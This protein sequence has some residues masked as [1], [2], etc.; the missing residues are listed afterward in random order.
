[1]LTLQTVYCILHEK[2]LPRSW[3]NAANK[4]R[5]CLKRHTETNISI[6]CDNKLQILVWIEFVWLYAATTTTTCKNSQGILMWFEL[7]GFVPLQQPETVFRFHETICRTATVHAHWTQKIVF[8][9][10]YAAAWC[11]V[12]TMKRVPT[13]QSTHICH[14]NMYAICMWKWENNQKKNIKI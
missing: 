13:H 5:Q 6:F 1:M 11:E 2:S 14:P 12:S 8:E 4:M 7:D 3:Q 10:D 9:P